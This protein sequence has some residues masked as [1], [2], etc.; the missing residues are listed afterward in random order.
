MKTSNLVINENWSIETTVDSCVLVH[1]ETRQRKSGKK[2]GETFEAVDRFY[3]SN[4]EVCLRAY[5][6]KSMADAPDVK[7]VL[8]SLEGAMVEIRELLKKQTNG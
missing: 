1:T 7:Q 5:L 2:K 6:N 3:Y 8:Q 4:M